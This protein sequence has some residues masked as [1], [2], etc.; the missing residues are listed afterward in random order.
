MLLEGNADQ[1][2]EAVKTKRVWLPLTLPSIGDAPE[3]SSPYRDQIV[4]AKNIWLVLQ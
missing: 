2:G 4:A 1:I 3:D